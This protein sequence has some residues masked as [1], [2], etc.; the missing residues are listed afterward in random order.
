M[1]PFVIQFQA[2]VLA[3]RILELE[4]VHCV[5]LVIITFLCVKNVNVTKVVWQKIN[6]MENLDSATVR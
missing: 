4:N 5:H 6:V 1:M 2:N 3:K